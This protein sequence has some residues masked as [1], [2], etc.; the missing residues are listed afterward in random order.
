MG[1]LNLP[2]TG[3]VYLDTAP[4]IYSVERH[5]NYWA[6]LQPLWAASQTGQIVPA[7]SALTLLETLVLP[8]KQGNSALVTD[9][10]DILTG[11]EMRL[12]P[13]TSNILRQAAQLR[14]QYNFKTPDA[15][16]A[17]TALASGC[18]QLV[19]NDA[20][21]GRVPGLNVVV[22]HELITP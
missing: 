2:G 8:L 4:I 11:P 9:Y 21:F 14:A 5:P 19:T 18:V 3:V 13:I 22:L 10:E 1:T 7:T 12:L 20:M 15:I 6:L 17:A 16:Q